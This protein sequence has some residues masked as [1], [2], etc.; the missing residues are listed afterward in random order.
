MSQ[1]AQAVRRPEVKIYDGQNAIFARIPYEL[2]DRQVACGTFRK[3]QK[4]WEFPRTEYTAYYLLHPLQSYVAHCDNTVRDMAR[5]YELAQQAKSMDTLPD[6][7][8]PGM[9]STP[10]GHQ[11]KAH[12]FARELHGAALLMGMGCISG[13]ARIVCNRAGKT[14]YYD[15]ATLYKKFNCLDNHVSR[16]NPNIKWYCRSLK[17][18]RFG[19]N[20]IKQ[21]LFKGYKKTL[22]IT[23]EDG[24]E[25]I[26]TPDHEI[27]VLG[28]DKWIEAQ[29]L[30]EGQEIL[31]NG[32]ITSSYTQ[33]IDCGKKLYRP[34]SKNRDNPRCKKCYKIYLST[35]R[36]EKNPAYNGGKFKDKDGYIR[37]YNPKH[38]RANRS[39]HVYEHIVVM[40]NKLGRLLN[41]DEVVHHKDGDKT[42]NYKENLELYKSQ[43]EHLQKHDN[44]LN[45]DEGM[46]GKG[47][48]IVIVPKKM[49]VIS[50]VT[51]GITDVYDIVMKDPYRNFIA[52]GFIVHNCGKTLT[53]ISLFKT[54]KHSINLIV[55]PKSVLDVWPHEFRKHLDESWLI[56]APLKKTV[57]ERAKEA[58]KWLDFAK[59]KGQPYVLL[60]NYEAFWRNDY[61]KLL[62]DVHWDHIVYDECHKL[63]DPTSNTSKF[64][65]KLV[66]NSTYRLGLTGTSMPNSPLDI[67]SQYKAI[68]P[69]VFGNS[70]YRFKLTYTE[71]GGFQGREVVNYI[72][73]EQLHR[74]IESIGIQI[75]DDVL[76]LPEATHSFRTVPLEAQTRRVYD[77]MNADLYASVES[78]EITIDNAMVKVLRLQQL[79]SGHLKTD[80]GEIHYYGNEKRELLRELLSEIPQDEPVAIFAR[81]TPDIQNITQVAN[82]LGRSCAELTGQANEVVSFQ[83][84]EA[85]VLATQ[86]QAGSLGID[87]T[88]ACYCI[89]YSIGHS[90]GE[91]Q[92]A[93]KRLHRPGQTRSVRYFHLLAEDSVDGRVYNALQTKQDIVHHI[94]QGI[95]EDTQQVEEATA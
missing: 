73:Q 77:E 90:L 50:I 51:H 8:I 78:G 21:V 12:F 55:C 2:K 87:L 25:L 31:V 41:K 49:K 43:G 39:G 58:R 4:V 93:L 91:Y 27:R 42:N 60:I 18:D 26:C 45:M 69:S 11:A 76:D 15:L 40:E 80:D 64:A 57:K 94:L 68:D 84:G 65:H 1:E 46:T 59:A 52:N 9:I 32:T 83:K 24:R 56:T 62:Q 36:E 16:R 70:Y 74:K 5:S 95:K 92:Q 23:L 29:H 71:L 79:T 85:N 63:K 47:G 53:A 37:I 33:C 82:D 67:F 6:P 81:F 19:Y 48:R 30:N 3:A 20:E 86:V 13:D 38:H 44:Y 89:F 7:V 54:R 75:E 17:D 72:N 22:K 66:K 34:P 14:E 28:E 35:L 61:A 10:W 88:K